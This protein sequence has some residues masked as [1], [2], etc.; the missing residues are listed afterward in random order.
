MMLCS[1]G[2]PMQLY[3]TLLY[4]RWQIFLKKCCIMLYE[5]LHSFGHPLLN[6]IKQHATMCNKCCMMFHEMLYSFG[7][8]F[9][10]VAVIENSKLFCTSMV[11]LKWNGRII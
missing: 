8:R 1:L 10:V 3:C 6:T 11:E 5:M 2:H 9:K 4:S 7:R